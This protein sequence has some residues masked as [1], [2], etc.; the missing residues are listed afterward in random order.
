MKEIE[1]I[2]GN[3]LKRI[4]KLQISTAYKGKLKQKK[5]QT[6]KINMEKRSEGESDIKCKKETN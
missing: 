3:A 5:Q 4:F 6:I 2:Q 1:R